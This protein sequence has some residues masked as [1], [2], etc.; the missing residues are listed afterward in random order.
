MLC[1]VINTALCKIT[2]GPVCNTGSSYRRRNYKTVYS[3]M[4]LPELLLCFFFGL[5]PALAFTFG[6]GW[7]PRAFCWLLPV[8]LAG[9]LLLM[10]LMKRRIQG[11]TGDCCGA[12]FLLCELAFYLSA[13]LLF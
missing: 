12:T 10:L 1:C 13:V 2:E 6:L 11:Y 4:T 7:L 8:P 9:M 3:R 5:A